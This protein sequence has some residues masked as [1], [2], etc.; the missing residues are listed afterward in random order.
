MKTK[1]PAIKELAETLKGLKPTIDNDFRA[2][3]DQGEEDR[4][5]MLVT[6][7]C[8]NRGNWDYQTGDTQFIGGAYGFRH[9]AQCELTRR[10]NCLELAR[11]LVAEIKDSQADMPEGEEFEEVDP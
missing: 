3:D 4:P 6:I 11:E 1:A 9:W 2:Y 7:G 10:S 5:S 8:D